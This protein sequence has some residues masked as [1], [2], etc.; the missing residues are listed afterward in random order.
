M[1]ALPPLLDGPYAELSLRSSYKI[2]TLENVHRR[3][4]VAGLY[5]FAIHQCMYI[6]FADEV[7]LHLR[8]RFWSDDVHHLSTYYG[9]D[10]IT[11]PGSIRHQANQAKV[12][13]PTEAPTVN[14]SIVTSGVIPKLALYTFAVVSARSS[15]AERRL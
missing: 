4:P 1:V 6:A 3:P 11:F 10:N 5:S 15:K 2:E 12:A 9:R 8:H 7:E 14:S 13:S